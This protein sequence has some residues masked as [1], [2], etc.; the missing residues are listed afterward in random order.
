MTNEQL[1][2]NKC[3]RLRALLALAG[4]P[5]PEIVARV[6]RDIRSSRG[7]SQTEETRFPTASAINALLPAGR[8]ARINLWGA[9][10]SLE[11]IVTPLPD[12]SRHVF[13]PKGTRAQW[14][15]PDWR[16]FGKP[17]ID[18]AFAPGKNCIFVGKVRQIAT[19]I[20]ITPRIFSTV[21]SARG[22]FPLRFRGQP[23][24]LSLPR[25]QPLAEFYR[26]KAAD[27]NHRMAIAGT[28]RALSGMSRIKHLVFR[29]RY[30][31]TGEI[32]PA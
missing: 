31:I 23:I 26:I 12:I 19:P 9:A 7:R 8:P 27:V 24:F 11:I 21:P 10:V 2:E 16:A 20:V 29:I 30:Q 18:V 25:A 28:R 32:K 1:C 17:V 15:T 14:E 5:E 4:Q 6:V 3:E 13:D 22:I